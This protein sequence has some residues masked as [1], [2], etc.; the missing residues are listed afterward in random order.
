MIDIELDH[1]LYKQHMLHKVVDSLLETLE[2]M[3]FDLEKFIE[4][5]WLHKKNKIKKKK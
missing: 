5:Y 1:K 3:V 2:D 4:N